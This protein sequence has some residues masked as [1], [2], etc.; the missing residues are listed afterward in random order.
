MPGPDVV[1]ARPTVAS[2][3][4]DS[5]RLVRE[6]RG[7][8]LGAAAVVLVPFA[9]LDGLGVLRVEIAAGAPAHVIAAGLV[10]GLLAATVSALA[11]IFYAGLLDHVSAAWHREE[12]EPTLTEVF[13]RLPWGP[14]ALA[15]V[16][17]YAL[18]LLGLV[19]G[20]LPGIVLLTLFVLTGPLVVREELTALRGMR[21]SAGLVR[22]RPVLVFLTAAL[23]LIVELSI[24]DIAALLIG[25]H[26]VVEVTV[27]VLAALFLASAV[28]VLEVVTAHQLLATEQ[29]GS[30]EAQPADAGPEMRS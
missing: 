22:H 30:P 23:P 25:H 17:V 20:I 27:E 16:L 3:Y 19:A 26:V 29:P 5:F 11:A 13:R 28:G 9:V 2:I 7:I 10:Y 4:R 24:A 15:S 8:V 6:R 14:L 12:P 18:S 21:R 1:I